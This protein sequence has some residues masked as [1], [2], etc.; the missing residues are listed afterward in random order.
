MQSLYEI[1]K[2]LTYPGPT[3]RYI[4]D[5]VVGTLPERL[6]SVMVDEYKPLAAEI[7]RNRPLQTRFLVNNARVT[8]HHAIIPTEEAPDLFRL[9]G[10]ERNIYDLVVRRFL[11]VLLP[12]FEYEETRLTLT[13]DGE[14]F[15]AK[16]KIVRN[17]GWKAAYSRFS[18]EEDEE[19]GEEREQSLPRHP[20]G[21]RYRL[22]CLAN[23]GHGAP[24]NGIPRPPSHRHGTPP[25]PGEGPGAVQNFGGD[26]RPG[27]PATRADIIEKLFP[28]ST[29]SG[30]AGTGTHLQGRPGGGTGP[31]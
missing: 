20:P 19:N 18:L 22:S 5:D 4:S 21:D 28:R 25:G 13:V 11:A 27:H 16:G 9:S 29:S 23:V 12:P 15:T 17:Q 3:P 10:P 26:R 6:R 31:S 2:V 30:G 8:D 24:P 7:M 1:H 14:T